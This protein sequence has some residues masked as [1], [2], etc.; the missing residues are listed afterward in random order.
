VRRAA[1]AEVSHPPQGQQQRPATSN[2]HRASV[3][4]EILKQLKDEND[5]IRERLLSESVP[6]LC[7]M[8]APV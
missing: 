8:D 2:G 6:S 1:A 7:C 4:L 3:E 5:Q